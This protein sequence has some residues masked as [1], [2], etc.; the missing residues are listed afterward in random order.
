[1][2]S[3]IVPTHNEAAIL[4][5][6]LSGILR[7]QR[8]AGVELIVTDGGS[9]DET[10]AIARRYA[11]V[12]EAPKGKGSQLNAGAHAAGGDV[13]F[14]VHADT[15]LPEGTLRTIET[16][17]RAGYDGGGFSNAFES[18]NRRIK[19]VGRAIR[20]QFRDKE[21]D[22][23]NTSFY[24]DNGIFATRTAFEALGGFKPLPIMEDYDFSRRLRERFRAIRIV[25][26]KLVVSS[27]RQ[28]HAGLIRTHLQWFLIKRLYL[29]G[30]PPQ[31]L[32]RWYGDVR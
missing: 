6:T 21:N 16:A 12:V 32:A 22:P 8:E 28:R 19:I 14:F 27:R 30:V 25:D 2:I 7:L 15:W 31:V 17:V 3:I 4:D 1:M 18:H 29:L 23:A 10:V 11:R 26:P 20:F 13:F 5:D 9:T 24:G